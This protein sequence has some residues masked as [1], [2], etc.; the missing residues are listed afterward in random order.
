MLTLPADVM[1]L[2]ECLGRRSRRGRHAVGTPVKVD[3]P[4]S[5][6]TAWSGIGRPAEHE[7]S[8]IE[9]PGLARW[10]TAHRIETYDRKV[11]C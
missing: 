6:F 3:R 8:N 4:G 9:A 11:S 1:P 7:A 5:R 10:S 2:P